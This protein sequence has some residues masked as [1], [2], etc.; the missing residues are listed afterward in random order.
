MKALVVV[1]SPVRE[2]LAVRLTAAGFEVTTAIP[3]E[4]WQQFLADDPSLLVLC[5]SPPNPQALALCR[6]VP[7]IPRG[8]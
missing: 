3:D 2:Q 6:Q 4:A 8:I 1:D 7:A 5:W